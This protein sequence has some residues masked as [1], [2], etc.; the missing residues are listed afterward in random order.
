MLTED[1]VQ[2]G[3]V[4]QVV[5]VRPGGG[6]ALGGVRGDRRVVGV[7]AAAGDQPAGHGDRPPSGVAAGGGFRQGVRRGRVL[8]EGLLTD[9]VH[10]GGVDQQPAGV[11]AGDRPAVQ[12]VRRREGEQE[13]GGEPGGHGGRACG[14][15]CEVARPPALAEPVAHDSARRRRTLTSATRP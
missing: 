14:A 13:G 3:A 8:E 12:R 2:A 11:A 7:H 4:G 5:V 15:G 1:L 6:D 10:A 9:V